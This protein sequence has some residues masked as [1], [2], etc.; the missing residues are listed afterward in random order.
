MGGEGMTVIR[1]VGL[2]ERYKCICG[3][4]LLSLIER[5]EGY[6]FEE[7]LL[8]PRCNSSLRDYKLAL[9]KV[10]AWARSTEELERLLKQFT[11]FIGEFRETRESTEAPEEAKILHSEIP[12]PFVQTDDVYDAVRY[13][14]NLLTVR[15]HVEKGLEYDSVGERAEAEQLAAVIGWKLLEEEG[16]GTIGEIEKIVEEYEGTPYIV[17]VYSEN[18]DTYY[19]FVHPSKRIYHFTRADLTFYRFTRLEEYVRGI[20]EDEAALM[21]G[22]WRAL[23]DIMETKFV[24]KGAEWRGALRLRYLWRKACNG[25]YALA[26]FED[27]K[28]RRYRAWRRLELSKVCTDEDE[29]ECK[30]LVRQ[31]FEP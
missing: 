6:T 16:T 5:E 12:Y 26:D 7:P 25:V 17:P 31:F 29:E 23:M 20:L 10:A 9:R 27:D 3:S 14:F 21:E 1:V 2:S 28:G 8:C 11:Q 4:P 13:I 18:T 15:E 30:E 22:K 24:Y 19:F